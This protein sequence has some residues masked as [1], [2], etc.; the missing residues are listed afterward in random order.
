MRTFQQGDIRHRYLRRLEAQSH[1]EHSRKEV[2]VNRSLRWPIIIALALAAVFMGCS[3]EPVAPPGQSLNVQAPLFNSTPKADYVAGEY[4]VVFKDNVPDVPASVGELSRKHGFKTDFTYRHAIK[5]FAGKL[6]PAMVEALRYDSRV[7]YIEQNQ[8]V[9]VDATQSPVTWGLDRVDQRALPLSGSYTYS[10]T[11][12]GV[13]VYVID[14]GIRLTHNEFGGRALF[15]FDAIDEGGTGNDGH[16]HGTHVAGTIGGTTYGVAK[17][18]NLYAVRVL[19]NNGDGTYFQILAG[20]DWVTANHIDPA[21]ANMSLGGPRDMA[22]D[23]AV[24]NSIA[25]GVTYCVAAGNE[26]DEAVNVSPAA[27]TE[28]LTIGATSNVDEFAYFSNYGS[29]VDLEAPGVDIMSAFPTSD[30]GTALMSGTSMA[31]PH[32]AGAVALYLQANP[33]AA[34]ATVHAA[35]VNQATPDVVSYVPADTPNRLLYVVFGTMPPSFPATPTLSYPA[36]NGTGVPVAA[37]VGW[38]V[39]SGAETYR[40]Q[41]ATSSAFTTIRYDQAGLTTTSATASGLVG[42]TTYY[43]R[44]NATSSAGTSAWSA[45]RSFTTEPAVPPPVPLLASPANGATNVSP[46]PGLIWSASGNATSWKLQV[47][48]ASTFK[49][50]VVNEKNLQ[51]T[52]MIVGLNRNTLY[53]WRVAA[54]NVYG[55]SAWSA[56][57]KFKTAR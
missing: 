10:Y 37:P 43:W 35:I 1:Q 42:N 5:G 27:V 23:Q 9:H 19:D 3:Q 14:T 8:I 11:G 53:Y 24:R 44:V 47:S 50:L 56:A 36:N 13:N 18:V 40:V 30:Y 33:T 21:V 41:I 17:G 49:T 16:G 46:T 48:T 38:N 20:V 55:T 15:G 26:T 34:P 4:I 45:V 22:V 2:D 29:V 52:W 32:V 51:Q 28:A 57:W 54:T 25:A 7:A 6:N 31:S 12:A 39:S